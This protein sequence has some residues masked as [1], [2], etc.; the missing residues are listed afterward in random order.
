[1]NNHDARFLLQAY[2]PGGDDSADPQMAE[3][4]EQAKRD[5]DL[6]AW[7]AI[8]QSFDT[9]MTEKLR[10]V[11][12]PAGL[13]EAI[14]A[15]GRV[16]GSARAGQATQAWWRGAQ[17]RWIGLAAAVALAAVTA[18][19]VRPKPAEPGIGALAQS[20]LHEMQGA[21]GAPTMAQDAGAFGAWLQSPATRFASGL[22]LDLAQVKAG[23]CRVLNVAGRELL[24]VCF[25]RDGGE[26]HFYVGRRE[27]FTVPA[28]SAAPMLVAQG[29]L[30]AVT[31][32]DTR[33]VYVLAGEGDG[34][35]LKALL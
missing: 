29:G 33:F 17:A 10:T 31:W 26:F 21:H 30:A 16:S 35:A 22:P 4:L 7:L 6:G 27:D 2:R 13:R 15:G 19:T 20:A 18:L 34:T 14:L 1:M 28:E 9:A 12:P 25:V 11:T 24:E 5:P 23:G 8:E 3:A 32:A